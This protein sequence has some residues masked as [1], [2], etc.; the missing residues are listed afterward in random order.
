M[1]TLT[2]AAG[3]DSVLTLELAVRIFDTLV[4]KS[5]GGL[6]APSG[7][8]N[9]TRRN[10]LTQNVLASGTDSV[11]V[12]VRPMSVS[13]SYGDE[14]CSYTSPCIDFLTSLDYF[15]WNDGVSIF[16]NPVTEKMFVRFDNEI[17]QKFVMKT[18]D[19]RELLTVNEP[20]KNEVVD[21]SNL[22]G[23]VYFIDVE[24]A[25]MKHRKKVLIF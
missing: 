21:V 8:S 5:S 23:G 13:V 9:Y 10:C 18:I 6:K 11:F 7:F 3:C 4:V 24:L 12:P 15:T 17:P 22:P 14:F 25:Q 1:D 20:L 2:N 16:P 19:G